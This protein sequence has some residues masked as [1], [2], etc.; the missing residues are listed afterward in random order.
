M[1]QLDNIKH[2]LQEVSEKFE[3]DFFKVLA[4]LK[5][6]DPKIHDQNV[7]FFNETRESLKEGEEKKKK[8]KKEKAVTLRDF[9]RKIILERG[10]KY[11][12]SE[13]E[14]GPKE[15]RGNGPTY[16]QEQNEIKESFKAVLEDDQEDENLFVVKEKTEEQIRKVKFFHE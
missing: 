5:S 3:D 4:F 9:E 16:V 10:G 6:E 11:S 14:D 2:N 13:D 12:D 7:S 8:S 1:I 15:Q